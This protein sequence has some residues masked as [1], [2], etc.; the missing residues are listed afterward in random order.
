VRI[1]LIGPPAAGKTRIGKRL[2]RDLGVKFT[3][4][5][6]LIVAEHGPIPQ[7]FAVQGE[8]YFRA[9]ER[10]QVINALRG[11]GIIAFGGGAV[12]DTATQA[13]LGR[14]TDTLV[15]LLDVHA[16]V[17][18]ERLRNGKRPLVTSVEGW[19]ALVDSRRETYERL[20]D[21][22]IDTSHR[23]TREVADEIADWART[24]VPKETK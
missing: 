10:E 8:P 21:F 15:V 13:D 18:K 11:D 6:V 14:F 5:D 1:V 19:Q 17:V 2:A 23:P 12:M 7:I 20:A 3:D 4:T 22:T 24:R 16:E 9:L